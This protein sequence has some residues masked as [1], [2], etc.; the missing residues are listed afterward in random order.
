MK[1]FYAFMVWS[2]ALE[3]AL[4]RSVPVYNMAHI[5]YLRDRLLYWESEQSKYLWSKI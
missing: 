2:F 1:Y 3:L 5:C 4:A